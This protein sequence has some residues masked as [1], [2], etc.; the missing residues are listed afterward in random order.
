VYTYSSEINVNK[1]FL[2]T[3]LTKVITLAPGCYVRH[4]FEAEAATAGG[5]E[6]EKR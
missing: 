3:C 2:K 5:K 1:I 6:L 4:T